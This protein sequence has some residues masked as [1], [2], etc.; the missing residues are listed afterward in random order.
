VGLFSATTLARLLKMRDECVKQVRN[1]VKWRGHW[2][3]LGCHHQLER[4]LWADEDVKE[5]IH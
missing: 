3:E 5:A 2:R 1:S 4:L